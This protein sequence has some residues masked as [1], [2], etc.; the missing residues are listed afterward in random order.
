MKYHLCVCLS[1]RMFL[2]EVSYL[3]GRLNKKRILSLVLVDIIQEVKGVE[4]NKIVEEY[5][6]VL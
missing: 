1:V 6:F 4:E 5:G 3:T 2:E